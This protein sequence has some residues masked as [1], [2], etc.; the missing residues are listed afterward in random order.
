VWIETTSPKTDGAK[1]D[2][3]PQ[4]KDVTRRW[5]DN[6]QHLLKSRH[7]SSS[8]VIHTFNASLTA[9]HV[10]NVHMNGGFYSELAT[11]LFNAVLPAAAR[12]LDRKFS[13]DGIFAG[14]PSK[15]DREFSQYDRKLAAVAGEHSKL[16]DIVE[17]ALRARH[18]PAACRD[19][20]S[21]VIKQDSKYAS[22]DSLDQDDF[23]LTTF[24]HTFATPEQCDLLQNW[25][26]GLKWPRILYHIEVHKDTGMVMRV[27]ERLQH[28][29][30]AFV[31]HLATDVPMQIETELRQYAQDSPSLLCVVRGGI[32]V[33]RSSTDMQIIMSSMVWLLRSNPHWDFFVSLSGADYPTMDVD[34]LRSTIGE[35]GNRTWV[36]PDS[37][38]PRSMLKWHRF[39]FTRYGIACSVDRSYHKVKGRTFWLRKLVPSFKIGKTP[40]LSSGG[41]FHRSMVAFL[42]GDKRARA[43]YAY[44]RLLNVAGVEHYWSTIFTL[45]ELDHL[46]IKRKPCSM[47]WTKGR[48]VDGTHNTYLSMDAWDEV[49]APALRDQI[50]F[51]RKFDSIQE[52][53]V[54]DRIDRAKSQSL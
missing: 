36:H 34:G 45:P 26:F 52:A 14:E 11:L 33:W 21:A 23:R 12:T 31:I 24:P 48:G 27:V 5:N 3:Y 50:P 28:E 40:P 51:I 19:E 41:I 30:H 17:P 35:A 6:V 20:I 47:S 9:A 29:A 1:M 18:M 22:L 13:P 10:D 43:A 8:L 15:L 2:G 38:P 54:L 7:P 49:I 44:F 53:S 4:K 16:D 39:R 32:M 42:V 25:G 37:G 46:L